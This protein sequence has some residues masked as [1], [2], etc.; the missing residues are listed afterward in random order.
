MIKTITLYTRPCLNN[1]KHAAVN[2][3]LILTKVYRDTKLDLQQEIAP[4]VNFKP[5][6][7]DVTVNIIHY[8]KNKVH[9][10]IDAYLKVLLDAMSKIVYEDD[11]Q[12][13]ELNV[14]RE[15][16]KENPRTVIQIL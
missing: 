12:I 10:D 11:K 7:G 16:D 3:R 15:Y 6:A 2:G 9:G 8:F 4:Q 14:T 13:T 1:H 5:L